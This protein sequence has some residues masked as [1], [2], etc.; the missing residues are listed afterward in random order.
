M[1]M[2][3]VASA[4]VLCL[5]LAAPTIAQDAKSIVDAENKKWIDASNRRF[6]NDTTQTVERNWK[7]RRTIV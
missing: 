1:K 5:A 6:W 3:T 2:K 4:L 7:E